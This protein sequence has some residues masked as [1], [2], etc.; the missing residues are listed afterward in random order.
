MLKKLRLKFVHWLMVGF[1]LADLAVTWFA[2][3]KPDELLHIYFLDVGQGDAILISTA[4]HKHILIDGGP[5][6]SVVGQLDSVLPAWDRQ[7]DLVILTHPHAD[8]V[9]GL[10]TVLQRYSVE[11]FIYSGAPYSTTTYENLLS[12]LA[13]QNITIQIASA[14]QKYDFGDTRLDL[15]WPI[16]GQSFSQDPNETSLIT[17]LRYGNF[18]ALFMGDASANNEQALLASSTVSDVDV[19]KVGHHGSQYSTSPAFLSV[20]DP[21]IAVI[22]VGVNNNFGHPTPTTL[23]HLKDSG[24]TVY[25]TDQNGTI[26]VATDGAKYRILPRSANPAVSSPSQ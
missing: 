19:L 15:L 5:D 23:N 17:Q 7:L 4:D 26:E 8:H 18:S 16:A 21:E 3:A 22:E 6:G 2:Y 10:L 24:A 11:Q 25:R 12:A 13:K 9:A 14:G 20:A 1:L